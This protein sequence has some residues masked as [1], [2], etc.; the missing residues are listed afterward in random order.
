MAH[1]KVAT[2][3]L[4][5]AKIA[6]ILSLRRQ[7]RGELKNVYY[8]KRIIKD[9]LFLRR[10]ARKDY[11]F[12]YSNLGRDERTRSSRSAGNASLTRPRQAIKFAPSRISE[13][14]RQPRCARGGPGRRPAVLCVFRQ[15]SRCC[16]AD[17]APRW[18][19]AGERETPS[20][21]AISDESSAVVKQLRGP[22]PSRSSVAG[23]GRLGTGTNLQRRSKIAR[24]RSIQR[25]GLFVRGRSRLIKVYKDDR[26]Y[27]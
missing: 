27:I 14:A 7:D 4:L 16:A 3:N 5:S 17:R 9:Y 10:S 25:T 1:S 19:L 18:K 23:E 22:A 20:V 8:K 12:L 13:G 24:R 26:H 6:A 15:A 11:I 2:C 21:P